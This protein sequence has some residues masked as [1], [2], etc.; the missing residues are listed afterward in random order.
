M[1]LVAV[2][3]QGGI[4]GGSSDSYNGGNGLLQLVTFNKAAKRLD[5]RSYSPYVKEKLQALNQ[6]PDIK[7]DKRDE[8]ERWQLKIAMNFKERFS[9]FN[10]AG[11]CK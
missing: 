9:R 11:S 8:L 3:Y 10:K 1:V 6:L 7:M 4:G 5:M 2:D